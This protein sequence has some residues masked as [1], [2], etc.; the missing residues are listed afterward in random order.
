MSAKR[1]FF[2]YQEK[3]LFAPFRD[4]LKL[5]GYSIYHNSNCDEALGQLFNEP[6]DVIV[7]STRVS[8]WKH[9]IDRLKKDSVYGHLPI[10]LLVGQ[11][12]IL[13][14]RSLSDQKIDDWLYWDAPSEELLVRVK[15]IEKHSRSHLD[16]NPLTRLPGNFSI[17]AT[18]QNH[19]ESRQKF[20][21]CY[22]DI[23]N[24]KAFN[25]QYGFARGDDMIRMTARI[26]TNVIRQ[27]C[28]DGGFVGHIGGDDFVFTIPSI[29]IDACCKTI[30]QNFELISSTLANEEDRIRGYIE[31]E[32]RKGE[33]QRFPLPTLSIAVIDTEKTPINHPGQGSTAAGS[34]KKEVKKKSGSNYMINRRKLMVK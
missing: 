5:E 34:L 33:K 8:Q 26:I 24:F 2:I 11:R 7:L 23:D 13:F 31:C 4:I 16:A 15:L 18:L 27:I 17:M 6:A 14:L 32:D 22:V 19:I 9:F 1:I 12:D 3:E 29:H 30:I 21:L 25:D 10:I 28:S 20:A